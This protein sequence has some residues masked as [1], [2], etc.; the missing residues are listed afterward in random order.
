MP[1]PMRFSRIQ[2]ASAFELNKQIL[3]DSGQGI[4]R[5]QKKLNGKFLQLNVPDFAPPDTP[6]AI[7]RGADT[8][9]NIAHN[10]IDIICSPPKHV[11]AEL[12]SSI[13][14]AYQRAIQ[15]IDTLS[16]ETTKY[17]WSGMVLAIDYP[18][19]SGEKNPLLNVTPVFDKIIGVQRAGRPLCSFQLQFGFVENG[20]NKN[21][22][23]AGYQTREVHLPQ[24]PPMM[25]RFIL[26]LTDTPVKESGVQ[27]VLD[28][29]NKPTQEK[30]GP[31]AD[32][33]A[34]IEALNAMHLNS[35]NDLNLTGILR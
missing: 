16:S 18:S 19:S 24:P 29:N 20:L 35:I 15:A 4:L 22:T 25:K 34:I 7:I 9:I 31:K 2:I 27:L 17:E 12:S 30:I 10:R 32:L 14:F 6:R 33:D 3:L 23:I 5:L 21:Y 28:V 26:D 11:E 8:L 13:N 1:S